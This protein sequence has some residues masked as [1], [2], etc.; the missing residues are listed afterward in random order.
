MNAFALIA[1]AACC[2]CAVAGYRLGHRDGER[3]WRSTGTIRWYEG[4]RR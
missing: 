2:V 3:T 1:I 4:A